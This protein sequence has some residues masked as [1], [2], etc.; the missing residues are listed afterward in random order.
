MVVHE[1]GFFLLALG[2]TSDTRTTTGR[3]TSLVSDAAKANEQMAR[4]P[5]AP[6]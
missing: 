5:L 6:L 1:C 2:D 3:P 4:H